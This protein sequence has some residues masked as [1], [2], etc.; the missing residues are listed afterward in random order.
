MWPVKNMRASPEFCARVLAR[1]PNV[2]KELINYGARCSSNFC[3]SNC[4][5]AVLQMAT[6]DQHGNLIKAMALRVK[7]R[8]APTSK[9]CSVELLAPHP[10]NRGGAYPSGNHVQPLV[11]TQFSFCILF[12]R[13]PLRGCSRVRRAVLIQYQ[14]PVSCRV[15]TCRVDTLIVNQ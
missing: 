7:Y 4:W 2:H 1:M 10:Y 3:S 13:S 15:D 14:A 8:T 11:S 5:T 12:I 9:R 6:P